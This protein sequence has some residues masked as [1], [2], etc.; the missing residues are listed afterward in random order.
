MMQSPFFREKKILIVDTVMQERTSKTWCFWEK[1]DDIFEPV[2]YH[3]WQEMEIMV[4]GAACNYSLAP[5]AYKMVRSQDLFHYV[6]ETAAS[7]PNIHWHQA[8]ISDTGNEG[9][10]AFAVVNNEKIY[11]GMLF[12]SITDNDYWKQQPGRH[13]LLQHFKGRM[14]ETDKPAFRPD[15]ARLMDFRTKQGP[16]T[17]FF[18]VLPVAAS[19]A[20]VEFTVF[21]EELLLPEQYDTALDN[22]IENVLNI[23]TYRVTETETGIIPMTSHRF[24]RQQ[25]NII[26]IGT[27]GGDTKAS[28][29]YT[30]SA[31]QKTTTQIVAALEQNKPPRLLTPWFKRRFELYDSTLLRILRH[32]SMPGDEIFFRLFHRNNPSTIFR[33]LDNETSLPGELPVF[34]SLPIAVFLP[35]FCKELFPQR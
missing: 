34:A 8:A 33:F 1:Q 15:M 17:H 26:H 22:Y 35:A 30:F 20:L 24:P 7:F 4:T 9:R 29:G 3:R 27:A 2:V 25:G 28:T 31:I 11:A 19:K 23:K 18:Y 5:Y 13:Y 10:Y 12:N 32:G 14:I 16:G 21:S 6:K